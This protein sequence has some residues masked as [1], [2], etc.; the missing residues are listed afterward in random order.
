MKQEAWLTVK[1][2]QNYVASMATISEWISV[3]GKDIFS[4]FFKVR[5]EELNG[6]IFSP[7]QKEGQFFPHT[8]GGWG[9]PSQSTS[10]TTRLRITQ[11]TCIIQRRLLF[12]KIR[13]LLRQEL[14]QMFSFVHW[15]IL[16]ASSLS[17]KLLLDPQKVPCQSVD[18][19]D[20]AFA[21]NQGP[22]LAIYFSLFRAL[23]VALSKPKVNK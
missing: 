22:D 6:N 7:T 14:S 13:R 21:A 1:S 20:M 9:F 2:R 15:L 16:I 17:Q 18:Q 10:C 4:F 12:Q 5:L 19:G 23:W 11:L 3:S 8:E